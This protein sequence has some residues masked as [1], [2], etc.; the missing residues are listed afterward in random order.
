MSLLGA[1]LTPNLPRQSEAAD[2]LLYSRGVRALAGVPVR[3]V[4]VPGVS[5]A[6]IAAMAAVCAHLAEVIPHDAV[7]SER[8]RS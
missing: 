8:A 2:L 1:L 6:T 4:P 7:E 5:A 3:V